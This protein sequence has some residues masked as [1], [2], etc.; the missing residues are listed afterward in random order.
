MIY[1][2]VIMEAGFNAAMALDVNATALDPGTTVVTTTVTTTVPASGT[3]AT[4][5]STSVDTGAVLATF[6]ESA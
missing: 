4:T 6:A 5:A 1:Q 2:N 3:T